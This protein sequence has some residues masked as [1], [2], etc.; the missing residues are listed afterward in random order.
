MNPMKVI[1]FG[2]VLLTAIAI[3]S[4]ASAHPGRTDSSGKHTCRTNCPKWGLYYGQY[5]SHKKWRTYQLV[6][7]AQTIQLP[8]T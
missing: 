4:T 6:G 3:S 8:T 7:A 5:H 2:A 1:T